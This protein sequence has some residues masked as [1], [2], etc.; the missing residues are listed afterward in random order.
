MRG[1]DVLVVRAHQKAAAAHRVARF[2]GAVGRCKVVTDFVAHHVRIGEARHSHAVLIAHDTYPCDACDAVGVASA[3]KH[4]HEIALVQRGIRP[5]DAR[6]VKHGARGREACVGISRWIGA[7]DD[8]ARRKRHTDVLLV[9]EID[10]VD[11]LHNRCGGIRRC[12]AVGLE[13]ER[14]AIDEEHALSTAGSSCNAAFIC[15]IVRTIARAAAD[16]HAV[17][18]ALFAL[19]TAGDTCR[20]LSGA[21]QDGRCARTA[22]TIPAKCDERSLGHFMK[23]AVAVIDDLCAQRAIAKCGREREFAGRALQGAHAEF[24]RRRDFHAI[25]AADLDECVFELGDRLQIKANDGTVDFHAKK[26]GRRRRGQH[27][28]GG[29]EES[30]RWQ[31]HGWLIMPRAHALPRRKRRSEL[32]IA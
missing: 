10:G 21:A 23:R 15:S 5:L 29:G 27:G 31:R 12:G 3:T 22:R 11:G 25:A 20:R 32:R 7:H 14:V 17:R 26:R 8:R 18:N 19:G 6:A 2:I 16:F 4:V 9:D 30:D 24:A 1:H 28:Q 13:E